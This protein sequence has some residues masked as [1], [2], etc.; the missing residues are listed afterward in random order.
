MPYGVSL[1]EVVSP[2]DTPRRAAS[3]VTFPGRGGEER[4]RWPRA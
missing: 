4:R 2:Q 1:G 3:V